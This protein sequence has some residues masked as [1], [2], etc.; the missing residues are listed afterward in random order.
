MHLKTWGDSVFEMTIYTLY[1]QYNLISFFKLCN[2]ITSNIKCRSVVWTISSK[3]NILNLE[4][5]V[6]SI[7]SVEL[8]WID[9]KTYTNRI[10]SDK[11]TNQFGLSTNRCNQF[12]FNFCYWA[13]IMPVTIRMAI[14]DSNC[15]GLKLLLRCLLLF[16]IIFSFT[17]IVMWRQIPYFLLPLYQ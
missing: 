11:S 5:H 15:Y 13:E 16:Y 1:L 9:E 4:T 2:C 6:Y 12:K 8:T 17:I 7:Q 14:F 3:K 10:N